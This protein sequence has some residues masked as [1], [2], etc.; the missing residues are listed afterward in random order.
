MRAVEMRRQGLGNLSIVL[1]NALKPAL[2]AEF[3]LPFIHVANT[4]Q[5]CTGKARTLRCCSSADV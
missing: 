4:D 5:T 3:V 1:K 2:F